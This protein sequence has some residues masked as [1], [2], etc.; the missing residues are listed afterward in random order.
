LL[1]GCCCVLLGPT[2]AWFHSRLVW[3]KNK[4]EEYILYAGICEME[5]KKEG[6]HELHELH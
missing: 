6:L 5:G 3:K 4:M 1:S 2:M